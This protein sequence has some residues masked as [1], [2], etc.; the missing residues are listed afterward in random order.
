[1]LTTVVVE[2]IVPEA[3]ENGEA[4]FAALVFVGGFALFALLSASMG[5]DR[6][7]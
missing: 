4:R 3:H 2:E 7:H 6:R 1:V 5:R